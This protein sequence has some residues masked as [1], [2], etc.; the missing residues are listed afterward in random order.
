MH[1]RHTEQSKTRELARPPVLTL[2][3]AKPATDNFFAETLVRRIIAITVMCVCQAK[4]SAGQPRERPLASYDR[5][6]CLRLRRAAVLRPPSLSHASA[7]TPTASR[8][9]PCK[10]RL[11]VQPCIIGCLRGRLLIQE[12]IRVSRS[13]VVVAPISQATA[14]TSGTVIRC[15]FDVIDG[16]HTC[17]AANC[18][19]TSIYDT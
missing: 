16:H 8:F 11:S 3:P 9:P 1:G 13:S 5:A 15:S 18:S 6:S 4:V 14:R 12:Q 17:V 10:V 19:R 2:K 7:G